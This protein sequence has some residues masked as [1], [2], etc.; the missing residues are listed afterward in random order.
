M[1]VGVPVMYALAEK[2]RLWTVSEQHVRDFAGASRG[3]PRVE[4]GLVLDTAHCME[5]SRVG[6][7]WYARVF[8][9]A[10]EC[11]VARDLK[12]LAFCAIPCVGAKWC[13]RSSA[14]IKERKD[15]KSM[16]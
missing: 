15:G 5:L 9:F 6:R 12:R 14:G 4:S 13:T 8:G 16:D 2:D 1:K 10:L 11:A 7:G 3:S